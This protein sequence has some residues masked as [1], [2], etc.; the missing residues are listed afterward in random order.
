MAERM[1][2]PRRA[3]G[4]GSEM[5]PMPRPNTKRPMP[6]P[7]EA[8]RVTKMYEQQQK[9]KEEAMKQIEKNIKKYNPLIGD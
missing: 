4:S 1:I 7:N 8:I 6:R 9:S 2:Q 5:R 3:D